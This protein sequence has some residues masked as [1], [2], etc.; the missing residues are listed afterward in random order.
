MDEVEQIDAE[1]KGDEVKLL[2]KVS[3]S[4]DSGHPSSRN[5]SVTSG[6]SDSLS[7]EDR[8]AQEMST[9]TSTQDSVMEG[10]K[11]DETKKAKG[12][13]EEVLAPRSSNAEKMEKTVMGHA[14]DESEKAE[15]E[16]MDTVEET[17]EQDVCEKKNEVEV[18]EHSEAG[19]GIEGIVPQVIKHVEVENKRRKAEKTKQ[20]GKSGILVSISKGEKREEC[21]VGEK[22]KSCET[23][24]SPGGLKTTESE[25]H[26]SAPIKNDVSEKIQTSK[27]EPT[28]NKTDSRPTAN[29]SRR[30]GR[31]S[32]AE[33]QRP[34]QIKEKG[35][36]E[37]VRKKV[38]MPSAPVVKEI[39]VPVVFEAFSMREMSKETPVTD[40]DESPS[41]IE[42]EDIPMA[43]LVGVEEGSEALLPE[44]ET[45]YPQFD[46]HSVANEK[47]ITTSPVPSTGATYTVHALFIGLDA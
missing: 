35:Q 3:N 44:M 34:S 41:A 6:L 10:H 39:V 32:T 13:N 20:E 30:P 19:E 36:V 45:L 18:G 24:Y 31:E 7:T 4:S 42:M 26:S 5:F 37:T 14:G 33:A 1:P 29:E 23:G 12:S 47:N 11:K 43:R 28:E 16:D 15:M 40:S 25:T 46:S 21:V 8:G 17:L 2:P 9:K 38:T 27:A 22:R